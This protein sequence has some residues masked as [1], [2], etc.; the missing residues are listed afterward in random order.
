MGR[1]RFVDQTGHTTRNDTHSQDLSAI[2]KQSLSLCYI[3]PV[4]TTPLHIFTELG[5]ADIKAYCSRFQNAAVLDSC[6]TGHT[7]D[8]RLQ[9]YRGDT[10]MFS[11]FSV[12]VP[13]R[14]SC[15]VAKGQPAPWNA[16]LIAKGTS[17]MISFSMGLT[18]F[19][20]AIMYWRPT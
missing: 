7:A 3:A 5:I 1:S 18:S 8:T 9:L 11:A 4:H 10:V 12:R 6:C 13:L 16:S 14:S 19:F 15:T 2:I 17:M 20:T